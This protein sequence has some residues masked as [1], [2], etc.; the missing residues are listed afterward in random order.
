MLVG[1]AAILSTAQFSDVSWLWYNPIGC[2][3]VVVTALGITY[4]MRRDGNDSPGIGPILPVAQ[5]PR[6]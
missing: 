4:V 3:V 2:A 1:E 5:D 6:L